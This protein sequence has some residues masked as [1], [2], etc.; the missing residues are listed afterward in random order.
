MGAGPLESRKDVCFTFADWPILCA[1]GVADRAVS[2]LIAGLL[3]VSKALKFFYEQKWAKT[4]LK[5][6]LFNLLCIGT[7]AV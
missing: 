2:A 7:L 1:G 5:F 3:Q 4:I 6:I